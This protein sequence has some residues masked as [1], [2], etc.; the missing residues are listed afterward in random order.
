MEFNLKTILNWLE[1]SEYHQKLISDALKDESPN[2]LLNVRN[3]SDVIENVNLCV[4]LNIKS[5]VNITGKHIK[6]FLKRIFYLES[7]NAFI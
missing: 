6:N 7:S 3:K 5:K 2:F 4:L 1:T